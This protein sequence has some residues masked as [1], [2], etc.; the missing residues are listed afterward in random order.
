MP[1]CLDLS[2]RRA[3][4]ACPCFGNCNRVFPNVVADDRARR[5]SEKPGLG[6]SIGSG[7]RRQSSADR[8]C[9]N[10]APHRLVLQKTHIGS[11][12]QTLWFPRREREKGSALA[13]RWPPADLA[14]C[15]S[16][17]LGP[18]GPRCLI[19]TVEVPRNC[20]A[21]DLRERSSLSWTSSSRT[22][23][24]AD[25]NGPHLFCPS[26]SCWPCWRG[27]ATSRGIGRS[28]DGFGRDES[29]RA[30]VSGHRGFRDL[31]RPRPEQGPA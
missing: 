24:S 5:A 11:V 12:Q 2:V 7:L 8:N 30:R 3:F 23:R 28:D 22:R 16:T 9:T 17:W 10:P 21:R 13:N 25:N 19:S 15:L 14:A 18:F 20:A 31:I 6:R 29:R 26:G 27:I 4:A 1:G